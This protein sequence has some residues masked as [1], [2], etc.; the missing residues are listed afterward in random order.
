MKPDKPILPTEQDIDDWKRIG[1]TLRWMKA[2]VDELSPFVTNQ[3]PTRD[4]QYYLQNAFEKW[5][6]AGEIPLPEA[7]PVEVAPEPDSKTDEPC[8]KRGPKTDSFLNNAADKDR[9]V[10]R[11]RGMIGKRFRPSGKSG[12]MEVRRENLQELEPSKYFACLFAALIA[13]GVAKSNATPKGFDRLIKEAI[14]GTELQ[15]TFRLHYTSYNIVINDWMKLCTNEYIQS[16]KGRQRAL[17][18]NLQLANCNGQNAKDELINWKNR[19]SYVA[20]N[21]REDGLLPKVSRT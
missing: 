13:Y 11:L 15:E 18:P 21:A 1:E 5:E 6:A 4:L 20:D 17:I 10:E 9:F 3:A 19:Y 14:A 2:R 8:H 7:M 12:I 16:L